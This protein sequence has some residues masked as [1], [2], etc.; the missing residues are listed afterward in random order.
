MDAELHYSNVPKEWALCYNSECPRASECLRHAVYTIAPETVHSHQCVLPQAWQSGTCSKFVE[1]R[2]QTLAWGMSRLFVGI[3]SWQ[4]TA[5]R[6]EIIPLFGSRS[7]YYRFYRGEFLI[8]PKRQEEIAAI[9]ARYGYTQPRR[10]DRTIEDYF[11][12]SR[13]FGTYHSYTSART[14]KRLKSAVR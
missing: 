13:G 7:T 14:R 6:H 8:T 1:A 4:A 3:P 2:K 9:F 5:I 12:Q 10:Y 11:F